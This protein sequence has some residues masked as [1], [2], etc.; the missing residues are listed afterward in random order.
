MRI[1]TLLGLLDFQTSLIKALDI[2]QEMLSVFTMEL[3]EK[4]CDGAIAV[5]YACSENEK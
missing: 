5:L 1:F 3:T 2:K 4:D